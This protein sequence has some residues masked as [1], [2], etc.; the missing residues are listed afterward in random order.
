MEETYFN[1]ILSPY[2]SMDN[3]PILLNDPLRG[4]TYYYG[5]NGQ[6]VVEF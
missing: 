3:N 6:L 1:E 2:V 4:T 5:S